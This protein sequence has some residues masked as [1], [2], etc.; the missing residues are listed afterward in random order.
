MSRSCAE[1]YVD[2]YDGAIWKEFMVVNGRPFLDIPNNLGLILNVDWFRPYE[3]T[4]YSIGVIYLA[5]LNLPRAE[6]YKL[7][8]VIIVGC[9]P[10]PKEPTTMNSYLKP[11]VDD[12][13]VL[14]EG[15]P[16]AHTSC[17]FPVVIRGALLAVSCDIPATRKVCGFCG[18]SA[19]MGCS[20]C[21]KKFTCV[22]FG[23]KL[24]YS[25]FDR[26]TWSERSMEQHLQAIKEVESASTPTQVEQITKKNGVR[27]SELVRLPYFDIIRQHV[28]DAMH[29]MYLGTAKHVVSIWKDM[30]LLGNSEF[31]II[32]TKI[33]TMLVPIGIGRIPYKISSKF[34]ELTA[35]QWRNWT[36]IY[37]LYA[38]KG[39]LP[40]RGYRCWAIFVEASIILSQSSLSYHEI[41]LADTKLIE[42][43]KMFEDIY[44]KTACT[45]NMH[46]HAHLK[47]CILDYGPISSFWVF[48]FERYNGVMGSFV[49]N[50]MTPEMQMMRKFTSYQNILSYANASPLNCPLQDFIQS[51][52]NSECNVGS[53]QSTMG[54]V[55]K[56]EM[57]A[58]NI[59][60]IKIN[61]VFSSNHHTIRSKCYERYLNDTEL[62]ALS[63][64]YHILYPNMSQSETVS[65]RHLVCSDIDVHGEHFLSGKSKS[66]CSAVVMASWY[67]SNG[68]VNIHTGVSYRFGIVQYF[69]KHAHRIDV[70]AE[71]STIPETD[72]LFAKVA[73]Y[74]KHPREDHFPYPIRVVTTLF[75][76]EGTAS[77]IPVSR[78]ASRC[79]VSNNQYIMFDYGE[80]C[81]SVVCP[82]I[83]HTY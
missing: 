19:T 59:H 57:Y 2:I 55:Y 25:G 8:N 52:M 61:A 39:I 67:D 5:I 42:F 31:D 71:P 73:W 49:N 63:G 10:G 12:L 78:I 44:G 26:D 45:P 9:I 28:I 22:S 47:E 29:N 41:L 58:K 36:Y 15:I 4:Q 60:D 66:Q 32:Q 76:T 30:G 65:R 11:L 81:V 14:W 16:I 83:K 54:D 23:E 13:L 18:H 46:L 1:K 80:D 38:L 33:D 7:E 70:Q 62:T 3:H 75:D 82:L 50:W 20:K 69:L 43:C 27:Y 77:F 56:Q 72:H 53:L 17:D 68:H 51:C 35:D 37:S 34:S 21:L 74:G 6:R 64:V 40:E 79:A 24:D 48:P